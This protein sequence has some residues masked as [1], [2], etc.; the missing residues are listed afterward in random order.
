MALV[1]AGQLGGRRMG[2]G[3]EGIRKRERMGGRVPKAPLSTP[4]SFTLS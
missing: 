3:G 2:K 1:A 4:L